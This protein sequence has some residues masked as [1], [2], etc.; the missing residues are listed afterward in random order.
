MTMNRILWESIQRWRHFIL[1]QVFKLA[2]GVWGKVM[3]SAKVMRTLGTMNIWSRLKL[4]NC[5]MDC[6]EIL[7][8][9]MDQ[10]KLASLEPHY[11][12][13]KNRPMGWWQIKSHVDT[14][15]KRVYLMYGGHFKTIGT[16]LVRLSSTLSDVA[17]LSLVQAVLHITLLI[18]MSYSGTLWVCASAETPA[19]LL[20]FI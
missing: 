12:L 13:A 5:C 2:G 14:W 1:N 7:Y 10:P 15:I 19:V 3:G 16:Q 9:V 6:H 20:F 18:I 8:K 17:Q 4:D 11:S